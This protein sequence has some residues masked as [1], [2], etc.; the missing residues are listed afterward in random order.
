MDNFDLYISANGRLIIPEY[1]INYLIDFSQSEIPSMP[2]ATEASVRVAGR[3][4]DIVLNTVYE[5]IIFSIVCYTE[6]NLTQQEK[7]Q[8]EQKLNQ[9]LDSIKNKT[10]TFAIE[11][12]DKFYRVKYS[13]AM[14]PV[15]FP[16]HMQF[17]IPLKSSD[18][19]AMAL[20]ESSII[21]E[22]TTVSNT[23]KEVGA[24][25]ELKGPAQTP[26][27][28]LNDF[29]MFYDNVVLEGNTLEINSKNSTIT[30]INPQGVKTNAMRYYNHIFPKIK[31][32]DNTIQIRSGIDNANQ[33]TVKWHDL[34]L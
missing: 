12:D 14:I 33:L 10:K 30:M 21:G 6:D 16:A 27:F 18:S 3:D 5:P 25:F 32:G 23:I 17:T 20:E 24:I 28:S 31:K 15:N 2:E 19:Y 26:K 7:T 8:E 22:N 29:E 11:K 34:K 1:N 4:G 13:G 9:F